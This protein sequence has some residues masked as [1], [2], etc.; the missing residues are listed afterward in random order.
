MS[1]NKDLLPQQVGKD[2]FIAF[3]KLSCQKGTITTSEI[4]KLVK[5]K[6]W[7]YKHNRIHIFFKYLKKIKFLK[8][9]NKHE[10]TGLWAVNVGKI[11]FDKKLDKKTRVKW[12]IKKKEIIH[13]LKEFNCTKWKYIYS[14]DKNENINNNNNNNNNNNKNDKIPSVDNDNNNND[15]NSKILI[16]LGIQTEMNKNIL[17]NR[18]DQGTQTDGNI[19]IQ[20]NNENIKHK[21]INHKKLNEIYISNDKNINTK[22]KKLNRFQKQNLQNI[23]IHTKKNI[24]SNNKTSNKSAIRWKN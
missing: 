8:T 16:S 14:N 5:N 1:E 9:N 3:F 10:T 13:I 4:N 24:K 2:L 6:S 23:N 11:N 18:I 20:T 12:E 7:K 22:S 21:K 15:N 17:T 19:N